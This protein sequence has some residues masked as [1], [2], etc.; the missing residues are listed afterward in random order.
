M[1]TQSGA[2]FG[3]ITFEFETLCTA[4][5]EFYFM[6]VGVHEIRQEKDFRLCFHTV[7][8]IICLF[9]P[10]CEQEEHHGGGV[11]GRNQNETVLHTRHDEERLRFLH[12][13]F[14]ENQHAIG[15]KRKE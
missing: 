3:R 9:L 14:P 12:M 8:R 4:D 10:G 7:T 13:G 11:M 2:E 1:S 6:M 5:C 15:C